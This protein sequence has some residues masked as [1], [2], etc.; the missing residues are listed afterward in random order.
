MQEINQKITFSTTGDVDYEKVRTGQIPKEI[1][2]EV[3][4][5]ILEHYDVPRKNCHEI[6]IKINEIEPPEFIDYDDDERFFELLI[7]LIF[8]KK[9]EE[10]YDDNQTF[11]E[12][13]SKIQFYKIYLNNKLIAK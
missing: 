4:D 3:F 13:Y 2:S 6:G 12:T 7:K 5:N 10:E 11:N 1:L 9:E 8:T